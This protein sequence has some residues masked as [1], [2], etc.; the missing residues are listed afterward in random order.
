MERGR[1]PVSGGAG[2]S[3]GRRKR[4]H[5]GYSPDPE[6]RARRRAGG[7][8]PRRRETR[9]CHPEN[10]RPERHPENDR[11]ERPTGNDRPERP[12]GNDRPERPPAYALPP[13]GAVAAT[14]RK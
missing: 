3:P 10:D 7:Y 6:E 9:R 8:Q 11:P 12:S 2:Y 5:V 1:R 4:E 14:W 13:E